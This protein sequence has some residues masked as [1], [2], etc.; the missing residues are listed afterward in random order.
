KAY[1]SRARARAKGYLEDCIGGFALETVYH[2]VSSAE[3]GFDGI[4]HVFPVTCMPEIVS[5]QILE[6]VSL[7]KRIPIM[8]LAL[9]EH[10]EKTGIETRVEAFAELLHGKKHRVN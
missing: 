8:S 1:Y 10:M 7:Q 2:A 5:S 3:K 9:D 6:K 4:V